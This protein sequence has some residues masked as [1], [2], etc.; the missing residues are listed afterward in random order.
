LKNIRLSLI[1]IFI[2]STFPVY[3]QQPSSQV[4]EIIESFIEEIANTTD[5]E[6]DYTILFEDLFSY[7]NNP[8]NINRA[9]TEELEKLQLLNDFQIRSLQ[10]YIEENGPFLSIYELQLVYGFDK[11]L[12]QKISPFIKVGEPKPI[13]TIEFKKTIKYGRH[14]LYIRGQQV[15]EEQEGF[16]EIEDSLYRENPNSRYLGSPLKLYTRYKYNFGSKIF[17]GFTAE[18][19][20]GEEFSKGSNKY[21]FDFY[22]AH[23]QINRLGRIKTLLI[24]DY[25]LRFGQGLNL[26]SGLSFDKSPYVMNIK[27]NASGIVKYSST[28]ENHF[29]RGIATTIDLKN[30]NITAFLSRK[31]LDAKISQSDTAGYPINTIETL[32]TTG[33]HSLPGEVEDKDAV[34]ETIFGTHLSYNHKNFRIGGTFA[35]YIFGAELV[36]KSQPYNQFDFAGKENTNFGLDYQFGLKNFI[37]FGESS[38]TLN[39]GL[40][41]VNG[42]LFNLASGLSLSVLYRNYQ[43][44]FYAFYSNAFSENTKNSNERGLYL[45]TEVYPIKNI[46]VSAYFDVYSF[47]WLKYRVNAPSHGHDYF[48][49]ADFYPGEKIN[50]YL[51]FKHK[52]K[53]INSDQELPSINHPEDT[54]LQT[55]RYHLSYRVS[56]GVQFRNR[57]EI[58]RFTKESGGKEA[59]YLLYQDILYDH[60]TIPLSLC[61]RYAIF[62]TDSYNSRIYAYENDILYS[63]SIPAYY[64]KGVRTYCMLKYTFKGKTDLWIRFAQTY[65]SD[66]TSIG[67]GLNEIHGKTKSELKIQIRLK[68]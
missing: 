54:H 5:R 68:F 55:L 58:A 64:S 3:N 20:A 49:Q 29:F 34:S 30:L 61:F 35:H 4:Q 13:E 57:I 24:G 51:K 17:A 28:D 26:W 11:D 63:Y 27:K 48:L 21:G 23:L 31:M 45:G 42:A 33:L 53:Q 38:Y 37:L 10:S 41:F 67:S 43:R 6:L 59:G 16:S 40:A 25:H 36:R 12:V 2:I 39:N 8:V 15:L 46:K 52:T 62:D 18:K 14:Q 60:S 9:N 44:N 22:S 66:R 56:A 47:P 7:F 19:D 65:Y 1:V 32:L 50:M